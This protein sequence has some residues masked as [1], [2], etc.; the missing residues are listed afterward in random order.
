MEQPV[1]LIEIDLPFCELTYGIAPCEAV[2]GVTGEKPCFNVIRS[3]QDRA[4]FTPSAKTLRFCMP[5]G[6][7][8]FTKAG[9]PVV[10]IPS[11]DS[12]TVTPA[13]VNPGVDIG[14]RE[15]V[16]VTFK[17][18]Q[19]SDAGL[20]KYLTDRPYNPF[21]Q[22]TFWG[23]LRAR[24]PSLEGYAL[25]LI[26][27]EYGQDLD[28][29]TTYA[30]VVE[31]VTG[32]A[33]R[34]SL[35]AKDVLM[36]ADEKRAQAP[37][38]SNGVLAAGISSVDGSATLS[39][40]GIGDAEYPASGKVAIGGKE[41]CAFTRSGDTLTLTVR[42]DDGTEPDEHDADDLVQ[43][44]LEYSAESPSDIIADL[45]TEYTPGI[46]PDWI[47]TSAW[48][49]EVDEYIGRLYSAVI[50]EPTPV[51]ELLNELIEQVGLIFW[52]DPISLQLRLQS[53]RPVTT[54]ARVYS[55]DQI[56]ASSFKA[57][58]QPRS[59]IS[60]V[61]TYY[62]LR[63]PLEP[64]DEHRNYKAAIATPDDEAT[65]DYAQPAIKKVFSR[66][67]AGNN[68]AAASR[69]NAMLLARYRDAPRKFS[70]SLY[71][72]IEESPTLGGG[73]RVQTWSLQ[74]DTGASAAVPAQVTS[75]EPRDD[76]YVID[77][78][79]SIFIE[80][81][82][83]EPVRL[84]FIDETTLNVNLRDLHDTI[85][86]D[87]QEYDQ[88][89]CVISPGAKVGSST[90]NPSFIVGDWPDF[91][92]I[93][94]ELNGPIKGRGGQGGLAGNNGF[95][96]GTA[97]YTRYP[98]TVVN[99]SVIGGGGG[100]GGG[101]AIVEL[102]FPEPDSHGGG[103]GGGAGIEVGAGARNTSLVGGGGDGTET[104]GGAGGSDVSGG[105]SGGDLGQAGGNGL[106]GGGVVP[107]GTGGAAG[108]A[109]DGESFVTYGTE[110]TIV[111]A[112]VN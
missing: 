52:W 112:R 20:D 15:S 81:E 109:V 80:Q 50:A 47:D 6:D 106:G 22:G 88:I 19:H 86:S 84:I 28:E 25:R 99:N 85:Y 95:G 61:W 33:E 77:A 65:E 45:L 97:L 34:V 23:K 35:V 40:S 103:G 73:F 55:D 93:T 49:S 78:L 60:E 64:L 101:G 29:M 94:I 74:D 75:L 43:L 102:G 48:Q 8:N 62:G 83:L 71:S 13:V 4:N 57:T 87:P 100:G 56:I 58:E 9:Q 18:H 24:N 92:D 89:R 26:R 108:I 2:L 38:I 53:L 76:R 1:T 27:G 69:L 66:W 39:P 5:S 63:N 107:P 105:G 82:D 96:G 98:V 3:C 42:G 37:R 111:G 21:E 36:L 7:V 31:S 10:V 14:Q 79:E 91:V 59:R 46:D 54:E 11:I 51:V 32:Q 70:F 44:V 16:R 72:T 17:D 30:Y 90:V 12:V 104:T 110:G 67:I 68:R 41:I